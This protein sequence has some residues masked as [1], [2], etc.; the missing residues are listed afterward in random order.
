MFDKD[1]ALKK[2]KAKIDRTKR[3]MTEKYIGNETA[4]NQLTSSLQ[5]LEALYQ[6]IEGGHWDN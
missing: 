5:T 2:L 4:L 1:S 6:T 3:H